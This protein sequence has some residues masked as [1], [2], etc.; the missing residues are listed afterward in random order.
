VSRYIIQGYYGKLHGWEDL[1]EEDNREE[2]EERLR[3]YNDNEPKSLH[4]MK[5]KKEKA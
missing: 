5:V 3:E 1:C 4:R 2:A